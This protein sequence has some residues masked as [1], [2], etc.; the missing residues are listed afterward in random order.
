MN[1]KNGRL[2]AQLWGVGVTNRGRLAT[3]P[4]ARIQAP[5]ARLTLTPHRKARS[6]RRVT[7]PFTHACIVPMARLHLP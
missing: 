2:L 4:K 5:Q 3:I 6:R 7:R 1:N